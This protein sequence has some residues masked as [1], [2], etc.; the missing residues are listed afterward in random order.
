MSMGLFVSNA[1][2][3]RSFPSLARAKARAE[4]PESLW[5]QNTPS[6][7]AL[8][9]MPDASVIA[10]ALTV[11]ATLALPIVGHVWA[12]PPASVAAPSSSTPFGPPSGEGVE[13]DVVTALPPQAKR[14]VGPVIADQTR[15]KRTIRDTLGTCQRE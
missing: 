5:T 9:T 4:S 13:P 3:A 1:K 14:T 11:A 2:V 6:L 15:R 8:A 12:T 7:I 10:A